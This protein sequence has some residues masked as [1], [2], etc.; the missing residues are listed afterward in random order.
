[1]KYIRN[2]FLSLSIILTTVGC[3]NEENEGHE[4]C[5]SHANYVIL[6]P[7][8]VT[9]F[10]ESYSHAMNKELL[11]FPESFV[12]KGIAGEVYKYGRKIHVIED[13]KG[14]FDG[15]STIFVWGGNTKLVYPLHR[16]DY[17]TRYQKNDVLIMMLFR[18]ANERI[19]PCDCFR[20]IEKPGEYV[21]IANGHSVVKISNN[22]VSG[23]I[24]PLSNLEQFV[25]MSFFEQSLYIKELPERERLR[26]TGAMPWKVFQELL[27]SV[28]ANP[29]PHW[30]YNN[31]DFQF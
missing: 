12:I 25:N 24:L 19:F 6:Y 27:K 11:K 10:L 30:R 22:I 8:S 20:S 3:A 31:E 16:M 21:T 9:S 23:F 17:I 2:T 29:I 4:S 18:I 14:N 1:M 7:P 5:Y 13:M 28:E 15:P 26:G